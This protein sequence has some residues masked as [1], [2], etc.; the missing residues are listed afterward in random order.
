MDGAVLDACARGAQ[1]EVAE[2]L[3]CG[4]GIFNLAL[5]GV[6]EVD[7][8][9]KLCMGEAAVLLLVEKVESREGVRENDSGIGGGHEV[10]EG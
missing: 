7:E 6:A 4:K 10:F 9:D 2:V 1:D 8:V 3:I 5:F